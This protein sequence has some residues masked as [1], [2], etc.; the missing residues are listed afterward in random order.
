MKETSTWGENLGRA[1]NAM[2][3][4]DEAIKFLSE[5]RDAATAEIVQAMKSIG[6]TSAPYVK[7]VMRF[8]WTAALS[9][10]EISEGLGIINAA[11]RSRYQSACKACV[12]VGLMKADENGRYIVDQEEIARLKALSS[13]RGA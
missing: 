5:H 11:N 6:G 8:C 9:A 2:A 1:F 13:L 12:K 10:N 3:V 7:P 4:Y